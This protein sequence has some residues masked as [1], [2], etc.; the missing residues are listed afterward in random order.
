MDMHGDLNVFGRKQSGYM[1]ISA[2]QLVNVAAQ[3]ST[4]RGCR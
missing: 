4:L 3:I 1:D 2:A